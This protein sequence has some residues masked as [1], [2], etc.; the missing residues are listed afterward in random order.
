MRTALLALCLLASVA[1]CATTA[2]LPPSAGAVPERPVRLVRKDGAV[3]LLQNARVTGD[4]V[5]GEAG[6]TRTRVA[7]ALSDVRQLE[8]VEEDNAALRGMRGAATAGRSVLTVV[9]LFVAMIVILTVAGGG[10]GL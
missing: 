4:S 7:V 5:I 1:G 9:G 6:E 2:S 8:G 10:W 3:F